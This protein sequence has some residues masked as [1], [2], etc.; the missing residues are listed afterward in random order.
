MS[1]L[2][3]VKIKD[4]IMEKNFI[5]S[6]YSGQMRER[7]NSEGIPLITINIRQPEF[8]NI[9]WNAFF[10]NELQG[11]ELDEPIPTKLGQHGK[12]NDTLRFGFQGWVWA[13]FL[14]GERMLFLSSDS[15][16]WDKTKKE[17]TGK[18]YTVQ[19]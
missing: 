14:D 5:S 3:V 8:K 17:M 6:E 11:I 15:K 16:S 2:Y 18:F 7:G 10:S 19:G 4:M 13:I 9:G 1:N 12:Y